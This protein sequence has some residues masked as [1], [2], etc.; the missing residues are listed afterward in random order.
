MA[1][2]IH[3]FPQ[4]FSLNVQANMEPKWR[5]L[6]DYIAAS[7]AD[8]VDTLCAYPGYFSLSLTNRCGAAQGLRG[9]GGAGA[10]AHAAAAARRWWRWRLD[11]AGRLR[12]GWAARDGAPPPAS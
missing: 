5:Y 1:A 8:C 12:S 3:R 10:G 6:Q 7:G 2:C 11:R 4:L 9:G